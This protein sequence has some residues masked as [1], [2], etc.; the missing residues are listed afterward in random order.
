[1]INIV[2]LPKTQGYGFSSPIECPFKGYR[3]EKVGR[4]NNYH[5]TAENWRFPGEGWIHHKVVIDAFSPNLNKHLHVGHLRNLAIAVALCRILPH[6]EP[7]ALLGHSLGVVPE[8]LDELKEWFRFLNYNPTLYSDIE[9]SKE[10]DIPMQPGTGEQTGAQVWIGPL[11]PVIVKRSD[12]R[13]TYEMHDLAF[14]AKVNPMYYITGSEQQ[15]H[16]KMLGLSDKHLPMGLV[17]DPKTGKKMKSREGNALSAI[18]AVDLTLQR[19]KETKHPKE[20]AWN[21]LAW[22]FLRCNRPSDV[23]FDVEEWT[24]P[25]SRGLYIS[26]T[27]ARIC[28]AI[29]KSQAE[30][31]WHPKEADLTDFD[32]ALLGTASYESYHYNRAIARMDPAPLAQFAEELAATLGAAYHAQH[33]SGGRPAYQFAINY[34]YHILGITIERLGMFPLTEV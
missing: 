29:A 21:I 8:A 28:S 22:N 23:A 34:A 15:G 27:F 5:F 3:F 32:I 18:E 17:L 9:L 6:A 2:P 19:F 33:I 14:S 31:S 13:P 30:G 26:Y 25:D 20:L 24:K 7:V 4:Y 16:F 11:G 10:A 1:M 12:G